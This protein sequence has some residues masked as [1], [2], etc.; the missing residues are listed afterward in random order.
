MK[1]ILLHSLALLL[2]P[3]LLFAQPAAPAPPTP[4]A[5]RYTIFLKQPAEHLVHVRMQLPAGAPE[6]SLQLPVWNATYQVRDFAQYVSGL[7]ASGADGKPLPVRALEKSQWRVSGSAGG[8]TVEYD[9]L[10]DLPGPFG[11]QLNANHAFFNLALVLMYGVDARS[12]PVQLRLREVPAGWHIATA[13]STDPS[14][15]PAAHAGAVPADAVTFFAKTYDALVDNPIEVGKFQEVAFHEGGGHYRVAI[16]ADPA[17]YDLVAITAMLR[18][19]VATETAWMNDRPFA[20][21]LFIYH[22]PKPGGGGGMEHA[23]STAIDAGAERVRRD[24]LV[25][26]NVSAHEFFHLWN[27]KRIRPQSLE[28]VDYTREQYTRALW[29][30]EGVTSAVAEYVRLR[31]GFVDERGF[32]ASLARAI[33]ELQGRP[34]RRTQSAEESS[35]TA[36]LEK[37]PAYHLPERSVSY[38]LKGDLLGVLLDLAMLEASHGQKG[39]RELFQ[40]LN[41]HYAKQGRFFDDSTGVRD[42]AEA[43]TGASFHSFFARYVSGVEELPC[44][45]LLRTVGLRLEHRTGMAADPGFAAVRNFE[46]SP[47]A[48]SVVAGGPA[49]QAGLQPGDIINLVNGELPASDVNAQIAEF[50]PGAEVLLKVMRRGTPQDIRFRLGQ[51]QRDEYAI[52][53]LPGITPEQRARRAAW[54]GTTPAPGAPAP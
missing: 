43:V 30:S 2:C 13:L 24:P 41:E 19:I 5:V 20:S 51:R 3:V 22:F 39:L 25:L 4:A 31:A 23:Y 47:V 35:L 34:A 16:D 9:Y 44:A 12:H 14:A 36:W 10:A 37:Y 42:A 26:A 28:P 54:L 53:D 18:K 40:Y 15:L 21:Y 27:V 8:A 45:E 48:T 17:D 49:A 32:L 7:H 6:R 46:Q 33:G 11:T 38:Y 1:R 50:G 52:V 29:F